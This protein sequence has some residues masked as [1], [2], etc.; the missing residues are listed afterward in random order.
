M[1]RIL[2]LLLIII[3]F[4][5]CK[6]ESIDNPIE[7]EEITTS[8]NIAFTEDNI[9]LSIEGSGF[10]ETTATTTNPN[11]SI[12]KIDNSTFQISSTKNSKATISFTFSS[13]DFS[14][15]EE[16][17][18]QFVEHGVLNFNTVEGITPHTDSTD[19]IL[20]ILG[21]PDYKVSANDEKTIEFWDY[22]SL[23]L[24][25]YITTST[26]K[27]QTIRL[28]AQEFTRQHLPLNHY[29]SGTYPYKIGL[30]L[31]ITNPQASTTD[32]INTIGKN[33]V[34]GGSDDSY[35]LD[36]R[37]INLVFHYFSD[38]VNQFSNKTIQ[39]VTLY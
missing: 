7:I 10:D 23:G 38:D 37:F 35:Y 1:K 6:E 18:I 21:E 19:E 32:V 33:Y 24:R 9:T 2:P 30:D 5:S 29:T 3:L 20:E 39:Y 25:F 8:K 28:Y 36:Y 22:T 34:I 12:D 17:N 31:K 4:I 15:E 14:E 16:I 13:G 26:S 11:I 27:V